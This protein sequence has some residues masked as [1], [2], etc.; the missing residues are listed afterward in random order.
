[1]S[2]GISVLILTLNEEANLPRVLESVRWS[3]DVVVFD[4]F[5]DDR[6]V[7]IAQD[8]GARVIQRAFDNENSQRTA[9]LQAGFAHDWVYNPDADEIAD[10]ALTQEMLA[11]VEANP[12]EVAFRMRRRDI[13]MGRWLKH[14]SL[15]P[16]WLMRLFRPEKL[17]FER[18]I[19]LNYVVDGPE[20]RLEHDLL[21]Y[22]FEK[23]LE[24]WFEKHNKYSSAEARETLQDLGRRIDWRKL[25]SADP[26]ER[27]RELK[28][29]SSHMPCRPSLRFLYMYLVRRGF[30]DGYPGYVY[31][32]ML[33][34]Y[35]FMIV[36]KTLELRSAQVRSEAPTP[37]H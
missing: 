14:S 16:T 15:Y 9:S 22:S 7:R 6:T 20:G 21:H 11:Q 34:M 37:A 30:L 10:S 3:D 25:R 28:A 32:R 18:G 26:V 17:R 23:G 29:L 13:F 4:S 31:C 35:E 5:S 1:M 19:N 24:A 12:A 36:Q 2:A 27:R 8:F 33:Q